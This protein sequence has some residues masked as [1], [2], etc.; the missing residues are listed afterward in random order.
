MTRS[1]VTPK[2][3]RARLALIEKRDGIR[4]LYACESGSRC[5]GFASPGSD[6]DVRFIYVR[7]MDDYLAVTEPRDVIEE[8]VDDRWD[9]SGWDL[10][11]AL[12]LMLRGNSSLLEW[13]TSPLV[14]AEA[15]GF[16][17]SLLTLYR[18]TVPVEKLAAGYTAM[19]MRN[20]RAYLTGDIVRT[21]KYLYVLRPLVAAHWIAEKKTFP[22]LSFD[23]L[24]HWVAASRPELAV[25]LLELVARKK[26]GL[27]NEAGPRLS[28]ADCY[29][30]ERLSVAPLAVPP[31]SADL[32]AVNRFFARIVRSA[33]AS[34]GFT[35]STAH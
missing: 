32:Q 26:A 18:A 6:Y 12:Q 29:I 31:A 9:A 15:P 28:E 33:D 7:P 11:K 22:P 17:T 4:V 20:F 10:K 3:I 21:K 19:A 30:T 27:K 14:Y 35:A 2:E 24:V 5:W 8:P 16:R 23:K 25:E 34:A 13:L 1:V